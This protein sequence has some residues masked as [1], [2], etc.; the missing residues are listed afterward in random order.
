VTLS[1][2]TAAGQG[3][4]EIAVRVV[5]GRKATISG[6]GAT[7]PPRELTVRTQIVDQDF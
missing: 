2:E 3:I 7:I 1:S 5:S 6:L 4:K